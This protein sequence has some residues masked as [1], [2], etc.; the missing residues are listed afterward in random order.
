MRGDVPAVLMTSII[1]KKFSP[2]ARGC[3]HPALV[4]IITNQVFPAC[5]GMFLTPRV[6]ERCNVSFPRMRG[7]VPPASRSML[8]AM[9]F[10]PHAR[11]CSVGEFAPYPFLH[12]FPACAGMFRQTQITKGPDQ[13][14]PRMRGDVPHGAGCG[15]HLFLFSPHAR[16]CSGHGP[17]HRYRECVFPSYAGMFLVST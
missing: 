12:V 2:H 1:L 3:S 9:P 16:G 7:D 6:A 17:P 15:I 13:R 5:A 4:T 14:F 8:A 10:S 11:G